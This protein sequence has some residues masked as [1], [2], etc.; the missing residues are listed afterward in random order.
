MDFWFS[1]DVPAF[2]FRVVLSATTKG[3]FATAASVLIPASA[4]LASTAVAVVSVAIANRAKNIA[5]TSE[6]ARIEAEEIRVRR[7]QQQRLDSAIRDMFVGVANLIRDIEAHEH[8]LKDWERSF[9]IPGQQTPAHP[10]PPSD[11]GLLALVASARLE[12]VNQDEK[13]MLDEVHKAITDMRDSEPRFQRLKLA[14]LWMDVVDWRHA[15]NAD[16]P[17]ALLNFRKITLKKTA[18]D[19]TRR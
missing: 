6:R 19:A 1:P 11:M 17:E 5:E 14:N 13:D 15:S 16:R 9:H 4:A 12:A 7:E 18:E 8:N 2:F 10:T 3:G